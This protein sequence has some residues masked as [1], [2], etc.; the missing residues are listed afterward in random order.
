VE[1][2]QSRI[3]DAGR[4]ARWLSDPAKFPRWCTRAWR[5]AGLYKFRRWR[6]HLADVGQRNG[7]AG[8]GS[9]H[10]CRSHGIPAFSM[11]RTSP[12]AVYRSDDRGGLWV[13]VNKGPQHRARSS[14]L[15]HCIRCPSTLYA[16]TEGEGVF[17][18]DLLLASGGGLGLTSAASFQSGWRSGVGI[19]RQ[20]FRHGPGRCAHVGRVRA[21][22]HHESRTPAFR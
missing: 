16:A 8:F 11:R 10:G 22:S 17:R 14:P 18:L 19:H 7:P 9:R 5:G 3:E 6:S 12:P 15:A 13:A 4:S 1:A 21:A 20:R 2:V